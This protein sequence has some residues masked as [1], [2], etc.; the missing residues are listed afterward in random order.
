[1][2]DPRKIGLFGGTFDPPHLAHINLIKN[3]AN[4]LNLERV[5]FI[6][7]AHHPLKENAKI[8]PVEIRC[9]ML[10]AALKPHPEFILSKIEIDNPATSFTVDTLRNF[11]RYENL[12]GVSLYFILGSDNIEEIHLWKEPDQIFELAKIVVLR[13][14]GTEKSPLLKKYKDRIIL[15]DL[16]LISI[17]STDLR[18]KIKTGQAYDDLLH[19]GVSDV[20]RKYD[21]YI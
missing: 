9:E 18:E 7:S 6:P 10:E 3:V 19:E 21:L 12:H 13:R 16:P 11:A 8:T 5:Y 4:H 14:P 15:L 17:S 20:I 1:M 2:S